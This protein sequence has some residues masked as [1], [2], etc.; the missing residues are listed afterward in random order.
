MESSLNGVFTLPIAYDL[1]AT[2]LFALIGATI[3][4]KKRYDIVGVS[5]L[6]L[7]TATAGGVI[8]DGIFLSTIPAF[9]R[10]WRYVAAVALSIVLALIGR[11][12]LE[13]LSKPVAYLDAL[14]IGMYGVFGAQKSLVFGLGVFA[15]L[16][17]GIINA[18]GGAVV[19]DVLARDEPAVFKPGELYVASVAAG[20]AIF[21]ACALILHIHTEVAALLGIA[22]TLVVRHLSIRHGWQTKPLARTMRPEPSATKTTIKSD[23]I[24]V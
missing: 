1:F 21:L 22:T 19:R 3:G 24:D 13:R 18:V 23:A 6:A 16:L 10:D 2:L 12:V 11:Q 20:T 15:A 9:L 4:M 17:V 5:A 14:A 7:A 8:R